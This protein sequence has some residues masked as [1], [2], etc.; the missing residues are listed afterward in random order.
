[1]QSDLRLQAGR[2]KARD[3][4]KQEHRLSKLREGTAG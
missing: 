2:D 3:L 1:M 4:R